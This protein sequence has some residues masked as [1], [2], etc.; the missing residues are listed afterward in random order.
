MIPVFTDDPE[1]N[2]LELSSY[3]E[4]CK[5]WGLDPWKL[6][7]LDEPEWDDEPLDYEEKDFGGEF[8]C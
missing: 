5:A 7:G 1:Q 8:E 6:A 4:E 3:L 2:S